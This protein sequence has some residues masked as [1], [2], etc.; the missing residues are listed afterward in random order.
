[1]TTAKKQL[2]GC[3]YYDKRELI[4]LI[5]EKEYSFNH[6]KGKKRGTV[7][8]ETSSS[9]SVLHPF[10]FKDLTVQT[11]LRIVLERTDYQ[12]K[13]IGDNK[14]TDANIVYMNLFN[15]R[16]VFFR[17]GNNGIN[18]ISRLLTMGLIELR[19]K[20]IEGKVRKNFCYVTKKGHEILDWFKKN[21]PIQFQE[22][23]NKQKSWK[24]RHT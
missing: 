22:I 11:L 19:N 23:Y 15:D 24:V 2:F 21:K 8:I 7:R 20:T 16:S 9:D 13:K 18:E 10:E 17:L 6:L 3:A 14:K 12:V 5:G 1:M 4:K